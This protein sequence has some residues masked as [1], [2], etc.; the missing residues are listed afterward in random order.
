MKRHIAA[1]IVSCNPDLNRLTENINAII[2]QVSLLVIADNGSD[3]IEAIKEL[4]STYPDKIKLVSSK[5]NMGIA[6]ALNRIMENAGTQGADWVI[7]LDHDSVCPD[8]IIHDYC[9]YLDSVSATENKIGILCPTIIDKNI[10]IL[11]GGYEDVRPV[12]RCITS[13]SLTSYAGWL[14]V[15]G[16][17]EIMFIDGVDFD[18]CDRLWLADYKVLRV[19]Y[20]K[21]SHELGKMTSHKFLFK[22]V[23]VQNH[24]P[25]RKYYIVRNRF[26]LAQKRKKRFSILS[27]FCFTIKFS[28]TILLY[29]NQK[30]AKLKA[31]IKGAHDGLKNTEGMSH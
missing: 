5:K 31:V 17:D 16:F 1:G 9:S 2:N 25:T 26:Y 22:T 29:E 20:I 7:T 13:G 11:E 12:A 28:I 4:I 15:G 27:A 21:L 6:W 18:Y 10:G 19:G 30:A 8:S 23:R 14:A 24:N 3:N